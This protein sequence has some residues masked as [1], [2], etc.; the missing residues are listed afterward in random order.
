MRTI[1]KL[2]F[3][4]NR[5]GNTYLKGT[6]KEGQ[7]DMEGQEGHEWKEGQEGQEGQEGHRA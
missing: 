1:N 3:E 7:N 2:D 5:K 6:V 4:T